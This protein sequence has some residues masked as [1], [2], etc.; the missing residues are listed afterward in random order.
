MQF[1]R[2]N[3][4]GEAVGKPT[5]RPTSRIKNGGTRQVSV[6]YGHEGGGKAYNYLAGE[7]IRAGDVV[8]PEVT[9]PKSGK[10]YH[11]LAR[12]VSTRDAT[13]GSAGDTAG[14]LSGQG[15]M[16]KTIGLTNQTALP[17]FQSRKAQDPSFTTKKWA[18]EA[19]QNYDNAVMQ[20]INPMGEPV[21]G[22]GQ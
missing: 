6:L 16:L 14:Y 10:S 9:H 5:A 2:L 4:M 20:R 1:N 11:T 17:G 22:G 18:Q 21:K 8:T 7:N 13:G 3:A 12:V 15:V 19:K